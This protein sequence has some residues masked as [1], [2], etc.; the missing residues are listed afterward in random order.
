MRW[1]WSKPVD[2]FYCSS[3]RQNRSRLGQGA[4]SVSGS[5]VTVCAG[6]LVG[7]GRITS[8]E[9]ME[10]HQRL[11]AMSPAELSDLFRNP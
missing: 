7:T 8:D 9:Q 3:C 1:P 2:N 6:C 5:I 11:D 10:L 4:A